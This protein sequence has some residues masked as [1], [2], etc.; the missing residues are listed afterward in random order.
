MQRSSR[1]AKAAAAAAASG[2]GALD[3]KGNL[4]ARKSST[5]KRRAPQRKRP[6]ANRKWTEEQKNRWS[7]EINDELDKIA[8]SQRTSR[9]PTKSKLDRLRKGVRLRS[10]AE[11]AAYAKSWRIMRRMPRHGAERE[12]QRT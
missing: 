4:P 2:T 11:N 10:R 9:R 1:N 8:A 3:A 6:N 7:N 12:A 5:P